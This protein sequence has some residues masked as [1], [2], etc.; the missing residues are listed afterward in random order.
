MIRQVIVARS[1]DFSSAL[2]EGDEKL[3]SRVD[4]RL[5]ELL[6]AYKGALTVC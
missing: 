1:E 6:G 4:A 3:L 2:Q 5:R